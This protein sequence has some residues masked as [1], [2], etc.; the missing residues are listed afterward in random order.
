MNTTGMPLSLSNQRLNNHDRINY[1]R[2]QPF[3][4]KK[5]ESTLP[6]KFINSNVIT[7]FAYSTR[8]GFSVNNI[9]KKN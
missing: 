8:E 7:R 1:T 2:E 3:K 5:Y 4:L 6:K 9:N